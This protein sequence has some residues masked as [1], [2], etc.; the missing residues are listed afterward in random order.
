MHRVPSSGSLRGSPEASSPPTL[1]LPRARARAELTGPDT[2]T[3]NVRRAATLAISTQYLA[4]VL[5]SGPGSYLVQAAADAKP[6]ADS[7][8]ANVPAIRRSCI[9]TLGGYSPPLATRCPIATGRPLG[10]K[11]A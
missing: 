1:L 4:I 11:H 6:L 2:G 5:H 9:S 8:A 3:F 10:R 7:L